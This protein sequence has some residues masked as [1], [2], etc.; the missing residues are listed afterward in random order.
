MTLISCMRPIFLSFLFIVYFVLSGT[1]QV[2]DTVLANYEWEKF[3][4]PNNPTLSIAK[5]ENRLFAGTTNGLFY[6]EDDGEEWKS[7]PELYTNQIESVVAQGNTVIATY[8]K[9]TQS[10]PGSGSTI[11]YFNWISKDEGITVDTVLRLWDQSGGFFSQ[12]ASLPF[13]FGENSFGQF[14]ST[15]TLNYSYAKFF[16]WTEIGGAW[17][18]IESDISTDS[19][20][21]FRPL[22]ASVEN[23]Q[24]YYNVRRPEFLLRHFFDESSGTVLSID[25]IIQGSASSHFSE[26]TITFS[27]GNSVLTST[28]YGN[29]FSTITYPQFDPSSIQ[30]FFDV[31][32]NRYYFQFENIIYRQNEDDATVLDTVFTPFHDPGTNQETYFFINEDYL[33][34]HSSG[35]LYRSDKENISWVEK[36]KGIANLSF[37]YSGGYRFY[38]IGDE[39]WVSHAGSNGTYIL[40]DAY[41][42]HL[43][44][45]T[46]SSDI[47]KPITK[48][49]D[50]YL[51]TIDGEWQWSMDAITYQ[52]YE[53]QKQ[54][55]SPLLK[56]IED[57]YYILENDRM[58]FTDDLAA[59]FDSISIPTKGELFVKGDTLVIF[60]GNAIRHL[61]ADAGNT[62]TSQDIEYPF[63]TIPWNSPIADW[64]HWHN[65]TLYVFHNFNSFY[66]STDW[67]ESW[68]DPTP[69]EWLFYF[70]NNPIIHNHIVA[71]KDSLVLAHVQGDLWVTTNFGDSWTI[72]DDVPF[73]REDYLLNINFNYNYY[74]LN[75]ALDYYITD[76][77]IYAFTDGYGLQRTPIA[78]LLAAMAPPAFS[79]LELSA[80]GPDDYNIYESIPY[81]IVVA[82]KGTTNAKSIV[83]RA[84]LPN[85]VVYASDA[86]SSGNYNLY[87][88]EWTIDSLAAGTEDTLNLTLFPLIDDSEITFFTQIINTE[89]DSSDFDSTPNN[90]SLEEVP[91]EDDEAVVVSVPNTSFTW[92]NNASPSS[93]IFPNPAKDRLFFLP[94]EGGFYDLQIISIDGKIKKAI[95]MEL[96]PN[97]VIEFNIHDLPKGSYFLF[98]KDEK[99][100]FTIPFVKG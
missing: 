60:E 88:E 65:D 84:P 39:F 91:M 24:P 64:I 90:N 100:N 8:K 4:A 75:G 50:R 10:I 67:G 21:T 80:T 2:I 15:G 44:L 17:N 47:Q 1:S 59:T 81:Q 34:V 92:R 26:D 14:L 87:Y 52:S 56:Q 83:I 5:T 82:N 55:F 38:D 89:S 28:D 20:F 35:R 7:I 48:I 96:T 85:G 68:T 97:S 54:S 37:K 6:S 46:D 49:G 57:T 77:N 51:G 76:H 25:T 41:A 79:D 61:S 13:I 78:D 11:T 18:V 36:D 32:Q 3:S 30:S 40:S 31:H 66:Y 9:L 58:L 12:E 94:Q 99:R 42:E 95:K 19:V 16:L 62:W 23:N 74:Q 72:L 70:Y 29:N 71:V 73:S 69:G 27:S 53:I 98:G 86:P 43:Y 33:W 93:V 45:D 63:N 22:S